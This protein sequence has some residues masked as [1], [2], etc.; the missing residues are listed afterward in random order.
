M[1]N[2][3]FLFIF[4]LIVLSGC[5]GSH[6]KNEKNQESYIFD[7]GMVWNTQ[8]HITYRGDENLRDSIR[9][10]LDEVGHSLSV[11]DST[12]LVSKVNHCDSTP[13]NCD[14]IRV[15]EMSRRINK[16]SG[17]MFDPTLSPLI[18]AWGFGPGHKATSDTVRLDSLLR[19]VGLDKTTLRA[20]Y[21][22]K[23]LPNIQF[24]FSAIAK[25]Y[26]CDR[27]A[28]ELKKNKVNDFLVEIGGEIVASGKNPRGD[29]WKISIDRPVYS[30]SDI[31]HESQVVIEFTDM[32]L[33]TS[34]NYRNYH[35]NGS[36]RYGHTI[37]P[38]T[39]RPL[40]TD[41]LSAT[42]LATTSMEADALATAFMAMGSPKSKETARELDLPVLLICSD[43]V[44]ASERFKELISTN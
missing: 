33:A 29:K 7:E 8:F 17:G 12:S 20:G 19:I 1:K 11:F 10:V 18:T 43:T 14:F 27:V 32:G 6:G 35:G 44:W 3:C 42:V 21:I 39:G 4:S 13:V 22:V 5:A 30:N 9:K 37:S 15:Y 31:I 28:E 24:N 40:Q 34:G 26:G 25:G 38:I 36:Q 23:D 41:V 2:L 16:I